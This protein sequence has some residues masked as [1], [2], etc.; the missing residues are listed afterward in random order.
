MQKSATIIFTPTTITFESQLLLY[1]PNRSKIQA[2][3]QL[4][5]LLVSHSAYVTHEWVPTEQQQLDHQETQSVASSLDCDE[6]AAHRQGTRLQEKGGEDKEK[7]LSFLGVSHSP[8]L[9]K[10]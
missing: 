7:N 6:P 8:T 9:F 4:I 1:Q 5:K 2:L 3:F 10:H